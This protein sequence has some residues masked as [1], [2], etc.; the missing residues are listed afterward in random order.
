L[1]PVRL[2]PNRSREAGDEVWGTEFLSAFQLSAFTLPGASRPNLL[3]SLALA[4]QFSL[5]AEDC[6]FA[7][8][9]Y[10]IL[11]VASRRAASFQLFLLFLAMARRSV[12]FRRL[13]RFLAL[14]LPLLCPIRTQPWPAWRDVAI[15]RNRGRRLRPPEA[16]WVRCCD[17]CAGA[18]RTLVANASPDRAGALAAWPLAGVRP[19]SR[20]LIISNVRKSGARSITSFAADRNMLPRFWETDATSTRIPRRLNLIAR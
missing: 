14:S 10:P 6:R 4:A 16:D 19:G 17:I 13:A 18:S 2:A 15:G 20:V 1:V 9:C 7:T 3:R 5:P 11:I 12:F 8:E